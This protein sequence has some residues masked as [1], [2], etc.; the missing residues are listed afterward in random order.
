MG[1][2]SEK[3]YLKA[4]DICHKYKEQTIKE[5]YSC[6]KKSDVLLKN[7]CLNQRICNFFRREKLEKV[8][9]LYEIGARGLLNGKMF[10]L[11]S[12]KRLNKELEKYGF[13]KLK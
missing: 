10:G 4:L 12:L 5:V 11:S 8:S 9:Q 2:I 6:D 3:E 1:R 7:F 13:E